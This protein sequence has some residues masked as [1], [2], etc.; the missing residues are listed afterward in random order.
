VTDVARVT[1]PAAPDLGAESPAQ[2][3][4]GRA[5]RGRYLPSAQVLSELA[6]L[7]PDLDRIADD[8]RVRLSEPTDGMP[9]FAV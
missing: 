3:P 1:E 5:R 2:R 9:P 7:G 4:R 6:S 8:L